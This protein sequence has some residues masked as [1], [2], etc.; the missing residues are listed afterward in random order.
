MGRPAPG[1]TTQ[2]LGAGE[3]ELE[4][5]RKKKE[6]GGRQE[7]GINSNK[8]KG[9]KNAVRKIQLETRKPKEAEQQV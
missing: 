1:R 4:R 5:E 9:L 8:E 6:S 7:Q 3:D 2:Q